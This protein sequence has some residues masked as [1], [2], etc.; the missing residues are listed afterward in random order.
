MATAA[1]L[2]RP[3]RDK[4]SSSGTS[5]FIQQICNFPEVVQLWDDLH[6]FWVEVEGGSPV[7]KAYSR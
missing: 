6:T 7:A 4:L 5:R 2:S 1:F 3:S